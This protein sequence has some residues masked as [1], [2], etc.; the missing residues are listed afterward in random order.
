MHTAQTAQ[1]QASYS[2]V[3]DYTRPIV[4]ETIVWRCW[5]DELRPYVYGRDEG[6]LTHRTGEA[7]CVHEALTSR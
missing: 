5:Y 4:R 2:L 3:L 6:R 1:A 7:W